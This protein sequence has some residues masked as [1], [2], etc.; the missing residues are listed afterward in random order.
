[1]A[2]REVSVDVKA[3]NLGKQIRDMRLRK[4]FTLQNI[5]DLTGLSK[6]LLS[7]IENDVTLPPIATLLKI[8]KALG[9]HIGDFFQET[10][11][12]HKRIAV[13]RQEERRETM[14]RLHE[15][16]ERVG[17]RYESL[18]YPMRDK[19]MEPF[20]V[21]IEPQEEKNTPVYQHMGEEF[22]FVLEGEME[23]RGDDQVIVLRPGD[24]LYFDSKIPHALRGLKG[25]KV[26]VLAVIYTPE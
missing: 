7:Q 15:E 16:A 6:P 10:V 13:V 20:I 5:S 25:R 14:R 22:L 11:S 2:D 19:C 21:E 18:A 3:L 9:K 12:N 23:F 8:S 26:R 4:G 1:M 17:Y 24:S